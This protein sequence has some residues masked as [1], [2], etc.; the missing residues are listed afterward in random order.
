MKSPSPNH[1]NGR[2]T[3]GRFAKGNA[4]GPGNPYAKRI[5]NLRACFLASVTE[6]DIIAIA[7]KIV[8]SAK[9]GDG[10]AIKILLDYVIGKPDSVLHSRLDSDG[11]RLLAEFNDENQLHSES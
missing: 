9:S 3:N 11:A 2:D 1:L 10:A 8:E 5:A 7:T 6:L 4:G